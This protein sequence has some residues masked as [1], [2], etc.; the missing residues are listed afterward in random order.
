MATFYKM[1]G[2]LA[3]L[4]LA[5]IKLPKQVIHIWIEVK[6]IRL[7]S[8]EALYYFSCPQIAIDIIIGIID[9]LLALVRR[10]LRERLKSSPKHLFIV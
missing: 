7:F 2:D 5:E 9:G 4:D 8:I 10:H 1:I 6:S 3:K